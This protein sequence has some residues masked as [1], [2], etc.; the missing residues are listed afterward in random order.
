MNDVHEMYIEGVKAALLAVREN[1]YIRQYQP[2][3]SSNPNAIEYTISN[4]K[5]TDIE[6]RLTGGK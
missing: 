5:L 1:G 3:Y 4:N 6:A 2:Q